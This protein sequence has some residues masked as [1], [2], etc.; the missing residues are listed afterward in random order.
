[1]KITIKRS[2]R[3]LFS[4]LCVLAAIS[5]CV[6][7]VYKYRLDEDLSVITYQK[8]YERE[9]D[10]YPTVSLCFNNPFMAKRLAESGVNE[11]AYL[12][13]LTGEYF[14]DEMFERKSLLVSAVK[15]GGDGR[16][17]TPHLNT[18]VVSCQIRGKRKI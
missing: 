6:Y 15:Q 14:S 10:V 13:F 8:F 3:Y 4:V 2:L 9:N 5:I 7:W 16:V 12:S 11:S 18:N 1:M 17:D